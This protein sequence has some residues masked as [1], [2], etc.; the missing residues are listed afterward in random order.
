MKTRWKV[1][2]G[3]VAAL[4]AAYFFLVKTNQAPGDCHFKLSIAELRALAVSMPG[5][6]PSEV[7]VERIAGFRMPAA[8]VVTCEPWSLT[9]MP[10]YAYQVVFPSRT[11]VVDTAMSAADAAKAHASGYD[12]A[13]WTRLT[14][15]MS[16]ASAIYVTHEHAD[17]LGGLVANLQSNVLAAARL[18]KE[19]L[20]HPERLSPVVMPPSAAAQLHPIS[21]EGAMAV[22]PGV[23]LVKAP[24][25]T[26]GS[27]FVFIQLAGGQELLLLG[28]TAWH[29]ENID[30]VRGP[31]RLTSLMLK[32][33]R[34]ANLCQLEAIH[35]LGAKEASLHIVPGH[36]GGVVAAL[37]SQGVLISGFK[38]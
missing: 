33:D 1:L 21:Y 20:E 29:R 19:Q 28:D 7:R 27:Q 23:V 32:N 9:D 11:I 4:A 8:I 35:D 12:E 18:T 38:Q 10:M 14:R 37:L 30:E 26:P 25:H 34:A 17:H 13:A 3:V 6:R 16:T 36:D 5:E 22:A 2:F 15:A 31:P 24:G